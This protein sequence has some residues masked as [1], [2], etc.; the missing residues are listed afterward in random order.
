MTCFFGLNILIEEISPQ[1]FA[2][3]AHFPHY[4]KLHFGEKYKSGWEGGGGQKYEFQKYTPLYFLTPLIL[5][6]M[7]KTL[8]GNLF[9][10][11]S[12]NR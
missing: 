10:N 12:I 8:F 3:H 4:N 9:Q 5:R 7:S 2:C 11:K 1:I 6:V